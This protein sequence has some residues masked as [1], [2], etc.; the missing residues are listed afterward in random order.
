MLKIVIFW[1]RPPNEDR[2]GD[3][4]V[5]DKFGGDD[6]VANLG[7]EDKDGKV[8]G[9]YKDFRRTFVVVHGA[10]N[11]HQGR[12]AEGARVDSACGVD[13][14]FSSEQGGRVNKCCCFGLRSACGGGVKTRGAM[15]L[16]SPCRYLASHH[17]PLR[18]MGF[19]LAT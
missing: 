2:E 18:E 6:L 16:L 14:S 5:G 11:K 19:H 17:H 15:A 1:A 8:G 13:A 7:V 9:N 10:N 3:D 12:V 4:D